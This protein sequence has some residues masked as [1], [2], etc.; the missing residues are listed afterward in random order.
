[1]IGPARTRA[2]ERDDALTRR[3][4]RGTSDPMHLPRAWIKRW[5][6]ITVVATIAATV[7]DGTLL[8][9]RRGFF[10]GGFLAVDHL[11]SVPLTVLF[12]ALSLAA[13]AAIIGALAALGAW[14]AGRLHLSR[15][16]AI[17]VALVVGLLPIA[18][19]DA[20]EYRL[21]EYFG[22]AFDLSLMFNLAGRKPSELL[23]VTAGHLALTGGFA[24]VGAL[25][26]VSA[27]W[28]WR[29][30]RAAESTIEQVPAIRAAGLPLVLLV[31]AL[32]STTAARKQSDALDN[33]LRRKP[34]AMA[35]GWIVDEL[36]DF[37]RDGTGLLGRPS[38]PALFDARVRPYALDVPGNG[39]DEDGVGGDLPAGVP[40]YVEPDGAPVHWRSRQDVVLIL[41]ESF[42][43]DARGATLN[44]RPVTPVLD[45][46]AARG[47]AVAQAY[48]H[49]GYTVQSRRHLFTGS[50]ADVRGTSTLIDDFKANGYE[51]AYFSGQDDS[52]GGAAGAVGFERADVAYDARSDRNLRYSTFTTAG[53]LAVPWNVLVD[54]VTAFLDHRSPTRPLFLYVNF[55]DTHFPYHHPGI[56]PLLT[57]AAV[58]EAQITP[59]NRDAVRAT[60]L[61]TAA[62]VDRAIGT[63]VDR[64]RQTRGHDPAVIVLADHGESLFDEGFL[65]HGYAL[66]DAQTHIPLVVANLPAVITEPFG[67]ADLRDI[68]RRALDA[69]DDAVAVPQVRHDPSHAL[70]QYLGTLD[71][72][73]QIAL[74]LGGHRS[75]YDFRENRVL[76]DGGNWLAPDVLTGARLADFQAL[77]RTWERMR[78]ARVAAGHS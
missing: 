31:I 26:V 67:Q 36:T 13:D 37:D 17:V 58:T 56:A 41:L 75:V 50:V 46:L 6:S 72:P 39:V 73:G 70:F 28:L 15:L 12:V 78:L 23:A 65:G 7:A 35:L 74:T 25:I 47:V 2:A 69:P 10:T 4:T 18:I 64:V 61:N 76:F 14:A 53:S 44:G 9:I 11:T 34:S 60:Y 68:V 8:Q 30:R 55:E 71:R 38:D 63:V 1:M 66:N 40:P 62:N 48:S 20:V 77:V 19:A 54:R 43:A 32:V 29:R 51:T 5:V 42:R 57:S 33:G 24:I 16:E 27:A 22:D 52:F 45:A 59:Q 3:P 49:N 21:S